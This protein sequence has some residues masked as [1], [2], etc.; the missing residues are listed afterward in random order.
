MATEESSDQQA[1]EHNEEPVLLDAM[2]HAVGNTRTCK[3]ES[4]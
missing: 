4:E 1:D 3:A 2:T